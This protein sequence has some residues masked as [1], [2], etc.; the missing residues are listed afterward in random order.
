MS[1]VIKIASAISNEGLS[2]VL[3]ALVVV[4]LYMLI[5]KFPKLAKDYVDSRKCNEDELKST[6]K[7]LQDQL[8]KQLEIIT[9]VA[10][11]G[12]EAQKRG[13]TVI[14]QNT[15]AF[16]SAQKINEQM[17]SSII[18]LKDTVSVIDD[19]VEENRDIAQKALVEANKIGETLKDHH[20]L[21]NKMHTGIVRV[22]EMLR[23]G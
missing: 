18:D 22:E 21:A 9:T 17:I 11:Q 3:S 19:S 7:N 14:E 4:F 20:N 16:T 2:I 5:F 8:F 15:I 12:I 1:D 13:N 10:Q 6:Q 23:K